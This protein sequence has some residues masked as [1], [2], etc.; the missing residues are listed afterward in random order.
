LSRSIVRRERA[1]GPSDGIP[2]AFYCGAGTTGRSYELWLRLLGRRGLRVCPYSFAVDAYSD[3][4]DHTC[5]SLLSAADEL[6][7]DLEGPAVMG[8]SLGAD[9]AFMVAN[10]RSDVRNLVAIATGASFA[11]CAWQ[12]RPLRRRLIERGWTLPRLEIAWRELSPEHNLPDGPNRRVRFSYSAYDRLIGAANASELAAALRAS[13][14]V[15][16]VRR[17]HAPGHLAACA[18]GLSAPASLANALK[19]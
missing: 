3:D 11:R 8:L 1:Y 5:A 4:V 15:V 17:G 6:A 19:R 10:R 13:G 16:D 12:D 2:V 18:A 9:L 14:A 7:G